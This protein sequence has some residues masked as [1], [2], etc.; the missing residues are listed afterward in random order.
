MKNKTFRL[1]ASII[2]ICLLALGF[3]GCG[4]ESASEEASVTEPTGPLDEMDV[5][6][7]E[8][9]K[10]VKE[11]SRIARKHTA[12][13]ISVT[14]LY[15]DLRRQTETSTANLQA[16]MGQMKP[17]QVRRFSKISTS[18]APYLKP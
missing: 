11:Y 4:Q 3:S 12:G 14:L 6:L 2:L 9:Q 18:V 13:D 8:Y 5:K 10:L 1:P 15:I 7:N 16:Q 17:I